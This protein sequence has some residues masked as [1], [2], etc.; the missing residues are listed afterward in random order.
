MVS[1]ASVWAARFGAALVVLALSSACGSSKSFDGA[2]GHPASSP[3]VSKSAAQGRLVAFGNSY[4]SGEGATS[5]ATSWPALAAKRSCLELSNFGHGGDVVS[6]TLA[7]VHAQADT[8][9]PSDVVA[10]QVG[11]NDLRAGGTDQGDAAAYETY[12]GEILGALSGHLV[13]LLEAEPLLT[14][15]FLAPWD[16]G[17]DAALALYNHDLDSVASHWQSVV[18]VKVPQAWN[19]A[20]DLA[21]DGLHPNDAGHAL[22]ADSVVVAL[23][24]HHV[25]CRPVLAPKV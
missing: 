7:I 15:S 23:K 25:A 6:Q 17:S 5:R 20:N 18:V 1:G 2:S 19:P 8:L 11:V 24:A 21:D 10:V 13:L 4:V 14:W 9:Q 22:I 3:L 12:I 16:K